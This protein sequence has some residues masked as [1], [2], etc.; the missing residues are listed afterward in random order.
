MLLNHSGSQKSTV[1]TPGEVLIS[2]IGF[3]MLQRCASIVASSDDAIISKTI[4]GTVTSW[5]GAAERIFGYSAQEMVGQSISR[6]VG[7]RGRDDMVTSLERI[8][9]G[10]RVEHYEAMRRCKDGREIPV[11][12]TISALRDSSG[13]IVGAIKIARDISARKN[14]EMAMRTREKMTTVGRLANSIA[15]DINNPLTSVTNLLF[16]LGNENLSE[17][18]KQYLAIAQRELSRVAQISAQAL[19]FYRSKGEPV[20]VSAAGILED[21]L[22]LHQGRCQT[23]GVEVLRDYESTPKI[24]SYPGEL[25]QVMVNLIGN[26]LDAMPSGGTLR[27]RIRRATDWVTQRDGLRITI[28]DTGSG[29]S[30]ETR[31]RLFEPFYATNKPIGTGMGLWICADIVKKCDGRISVRSSET[32]EHNGSV[33]SLI[34]PL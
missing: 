8:R 29:M 14:A 4:E 15:H 22:A 30:A 12:L 32:R 2:G 6:L 24:Y 20:W 3:E 18:G 28:A 33:F 34:L 10:E 11:S 17:D 31:R 13:E 25:R 23:L 1:Q 26:A 21:G 27:L 9:R 16:L 19:G 7:P 5:N